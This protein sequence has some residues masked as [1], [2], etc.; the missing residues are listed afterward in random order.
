MKH[1]KELVKFK[2]EMNKY[3]RT[4]GARLGELNVLD[5]LLL[6]TLREN[7]DTTAKDFSIIFN[8]DPSY[9]SRNVIKL[10][11]K[12][13]VVRVREG[14]KNYLRL[15]KKGNVI[16]NGIAE[17]RSSFLKELFKKVEPEDLEA[18]LRVFK[19]AEEVL[20]EKKF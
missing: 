3:M 2:N 15:T 18:T 8:T 19:A 5:S 12:R 10:E 1:L 11:K 20:K 9:M 13:L 7:P 6:I 4:S 17:A 14:R 16:C